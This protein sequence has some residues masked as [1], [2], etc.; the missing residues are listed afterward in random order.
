[1]IFPFTGTDNNF[2]NVKKYVI[3]SPIDLAGVATQQ[4]YPNNTYMM[5][6]AEMYLDLCRSSNG[7]Y[8]FYFRCILQLNISIEY[9][10]ELD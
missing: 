10:Q 7:K 8:Y 5:R 6:L 2:L 3:G 4:H 1:L 9:I